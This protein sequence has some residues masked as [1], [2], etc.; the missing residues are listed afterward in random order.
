MPGPQL[1]PGISTPA[2]RTVYRTVQ[3]ALTNARKHVPGSTATVR[4]WQDGEAYGVTVTNS[5]PTC[6]ALPLPGSGRGLIGL[7]E[8][9]ELLHGTFESGPVQGGGYHVTLRVPHLAPER[10]P[11]PP[12]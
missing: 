11:R 1:P 2:Q 10:R 5:P 12:G 3:E 4:L 7:R 6:T 9:A 8:R